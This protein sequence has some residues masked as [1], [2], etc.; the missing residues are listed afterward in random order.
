MTNDFTVLLGRQHKVIYDGAHD[1]QDFRVALADTGLST[2]TGG[3]LKR[4]T[5][6]LTDSP[7][8]VTY[9]DGLANVNLK[10]LL[11]FHRSH[12]RLATVTTVRPTSRFGVVELSEDRQVKSFVEK[13][14]ADGWVNAG[15]FVFERKVLDYLTGDECVLEREPL[16]ALASEGQLMAYAHEAS[17]SPW[18]PT[19]STSS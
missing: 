13:P 14:Q 17:S 11:A 12:G 3:R 9:G 18:I 2:M 4:V 6:Y 16:E 7:F 5:R 1:E 15:F 8:I 19:A 10:E